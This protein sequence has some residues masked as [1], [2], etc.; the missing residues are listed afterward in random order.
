MSTRE[1]IWKRPKLYNEDYRE[2]IGWT[3]LEGRQTPK[4]ECL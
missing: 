4:K 1:N 3:S 2:S